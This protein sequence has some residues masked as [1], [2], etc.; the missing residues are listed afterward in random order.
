M[1]F[2]EKIKV[3]KNSIDVLS[4]SATPIAIGITIAVVIIVPG[5]AAE[6]A[7]HKQ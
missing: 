2:K 7:E 5:P 1:C 4:L 3:L 6:I